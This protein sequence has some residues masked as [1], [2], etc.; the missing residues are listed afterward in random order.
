M[1]S[2]FKIAINPLF[3]LQKK[4]CSKEVESCS[5]CTECF[6]DI[7]SIFEKQGEITELYRK[8]SG[9]RPL[10]EMSDTGIINLNT[11]NFNM[12]KGKI[13]Q[14]LLGRFGPYVLKDLEIASVGSRP[15]TRYGISMDRSKI[16]IVY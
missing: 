9:T 2:F 16:A 14:D 11:D 12:Y 1:V 15:N 3:A 8:V 10:E 4:N 7:Q 5:N 13:K 6:L